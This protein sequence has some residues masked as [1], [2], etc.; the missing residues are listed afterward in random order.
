MSSKYHVFNREFK[1]YF[2]DVNFRKAFSDMESQKK[3]KTSYNIALNERFEIEMREYVPI[4]DS[5]HDK[6]MQVQMT[7]KIIYDDRHIKTSLFSKNEQCW[8]TLF[9]SSQSLDFFF[10]LHSHGVTG[11]IENSL[12]ILNLFD[13]YDS[14][15]GLRLS[16]CNLVDDKHG[17]IYFDF[18]LNSLKEK[19]IRLIN[20]SFDDKLQ[21]AE[22]RSFFGTF[23]TLAG[24]EII[25]SHLLD[26]FDLEMINN[27]GTLMQKFTFDYSILKKLISLM[28]LKVLA[29]KK[30]SYDPEE[31][32]LL[33]SDII[34][35]TNYSGY[36]KKTVNILRVFLRNEHR[37][38]FFNICSL[39]DF[40]TFS[41]YVCLKIDNSNKLLI[42]IH[43]TYNKKFMV[44]SGFSR[45]RIN[46]SHF[47]NTYFLYHYRKYVYEYKKAGDEQIFKLTKLDKM[48]RN[49][50][51]NSNKLVSFKIGEK[52]EMRNKDNAVFAFSPIHERIGRINIEEN[53]YQS[54]RKI[55]FD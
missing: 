47:Y 15:L 2:N 40:I 44:T 5:F 19:N 8:N 39:L 49:I 14:K 41:T 27:F 13:C 51:G 37:I 9:L 17:S 24:S 28:K 36:K 12:G 16:F 23:L 43:D 20:N 11:C 54:R 26:C 1:I 7:H 29:T 3:Y 25:P 6:N 50:A 42:D 30:R 4:P 33:A 34:S 18:Y 32:I 55:K 21:G 22:A 38:G 45:E 48:I 52:C 10:E 35:T 46:I 31:M 53:N